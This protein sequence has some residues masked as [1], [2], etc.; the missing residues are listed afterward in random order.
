MSKILVSVKDP[1]K[2]DWFVKRRRF[3]DPE[4]AA[5]TAKELEKGGFEVVI[6]S[7]R[8][9]SILPLYSTE[10]GVLIPEELWRDKK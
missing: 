5:W 10:K 2:G 6:E 4:I 8:L 1:K 9:F 7:K 3:K